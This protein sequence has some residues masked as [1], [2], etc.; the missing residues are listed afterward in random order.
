MLAQSQLAPALSAQERPSSDE[1]CLAGPPAFLLW[2][3]H[4]DFLLSTLL[5]FFPLLP[6][7]SPSPQTS[8][9]WAPLQE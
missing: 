7:A 8:V 6:V 1:A 3:V 5:L 2:L 9:L 4:L